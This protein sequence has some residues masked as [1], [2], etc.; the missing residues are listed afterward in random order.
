MS[1]IQTVYFM[2][3]VGGLSG[4]LCW[5]LIAPI[6]EY[7]KFAPEYRWA[8]LA[9]NTTIMGSLIGGMTVGF[10]DRWSSD[11]LLF[12]WILAGVLLGTAAGAGSGLVYAPVFNAI[13]A[14]GQGG[15]LDVAAR[16][17][18]WLITGGL[19]GLVTGLRWAN[20]NPLR[21]VHAMVGGMAGGTLGGLVFY[22]APGDFFQAFAFVLTG[23]GISL[24]VTLAPLLL[25][26]GVLHF[27]QSGDPRAQNKYGSPRQEWLIQ[28]G[29]RFVIG[30]QSAG[31]TMTRYSRDVQIYL[32]DAM[33]AEFHATLFERKKR[34]YLQLHPYNAGPAGEPESP[35][36]VG[37]ENVIGTRELRNGD[38]ILIGQTLVRFYTTK[39]SKT[40]AMM[41]PAG[42]LR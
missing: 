6:A 33:V 9:V 18:L 30:S 37:R 11:R 8:Q 2:S 10:A 26:E 21:S 16:T 3:L 22:L 35:L 12:R 15:L 36:Q 14:K 31:N 29:D 32:P 4:L 20:V 19:I 24:G 13:V 38:E 27:V 39:T 5:A 42:G 17:A 25:R 34:F 40:P 1:S 41:A 7:I 23:L 28:A